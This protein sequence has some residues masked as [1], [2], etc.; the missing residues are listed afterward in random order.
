[1]LLNLAEF[2]CELVVLKLRHSRAVS[3]LSLYDKELLAQF[4]DLLGEAEFNL[5][6]KVH[7]LARVAADLLFEG[8]LLLAFLLWVLH[9]L[10]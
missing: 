9:L 10:Q 1:L 5:R 7:K 8:G 6:H 2:H 4:G 3:L